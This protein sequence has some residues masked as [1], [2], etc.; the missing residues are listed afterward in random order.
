MGSGGDRPLRRSGDTRRPLIGI[1]ASM[2]GG[3]WMAAFNHLAVRRAGGIPVKITPGNARDIDRVDALIIGGG[4]D[5][6]AT[7][8]GGTLNPTIRIDPDR[9]AFEQKALERSID[10][11]QP[12]LGICR[13]AQMMN[14]V[15][16]GTLH[17]DIYSAFPN[18]PRMRTPLPRKTVTVTAGSRLSTLLGTE[19]C[20]VNALHHQSVDRVASGLTV[21][22]CD[23]FGI[24][25]AVEAKAPGHWIG[26]QWHPEFLVFD[27]RQQALFRDLVA[28]CHDRSAHP[29]RHG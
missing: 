23:S 24:V 16:G 11:D 7:L 27:T 12:V 15:L 6:S 14:V 20:R 26:V 29:G 9:D 8:Y 1:T 3:R 13:G 17:E 28:R 22:A 18:L 2:R 4:D 10:R 21:V 19:K 25:Q 5:I